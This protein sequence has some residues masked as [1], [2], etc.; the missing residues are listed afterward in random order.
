M[1]FKVFF[2]VVGLVVV[3]LMYYVLDLEFRGGVVRMG[4][5]LMLGL[6]VVLVVCLVRFMV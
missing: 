3:L 6:Y 2:K 4:D 1:K 5:G